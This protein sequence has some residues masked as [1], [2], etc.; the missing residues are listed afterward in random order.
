M[1][2]LVIPIPAFRLDPRDG[3]SPQ[4][5]VLPVSAEAE[6]DSLIN[7]ITSTVAPGGWKAAGG[8]G[9]IASLE[10]NL[11]LVITQTASVHEE[12]SDL[13]EE[14]RRLQDVQIVLEARWITMPDHEL[15][16]ADLPADGSATILDPQQTK[17]LV[18][19]A[20]SGAQSKSCRP[21]KSRSSTVNSRP[22]RAERLC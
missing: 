22:F 3:A 17:T 10:T 2:D 13:L 18:E 6:F 9:S 7:L 15:P 4:R 20:Q 1:A 8:L 5:D 12:I 14:L 19:G 11:S 16:L 21:P